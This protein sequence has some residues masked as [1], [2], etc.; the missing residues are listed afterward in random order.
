MFE[1]EESDDDYDGYDDYE[2]DYDDEDELED[3]FPRRS[4][5]MRIQRGY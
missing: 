3:Y 5:Y 2:D 1:F 4:P